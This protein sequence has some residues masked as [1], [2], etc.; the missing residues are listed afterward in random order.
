MQTA[1]QP[2]AS[3]SRSVQLPEQGQL[4]EVRRRQWI[5]G[6]VKGS[7][8]P[9]DQHSGGQ[10]PQHLLTLTSLE[11]DGLD[12]QLQVVWEIEPGRR[13]LDRAGLPAVSGFDDPRRMEAFLHAVRWGAITN[14]DSQ[15]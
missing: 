2:I 6:E 9:S 14:V 7:A 13:I 12:E 3:S 8:L 1:P 11:D 5:V 4:V 10:Q 15:A